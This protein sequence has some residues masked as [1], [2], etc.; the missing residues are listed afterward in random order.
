MSKI[1][2]LTILVCLIAGNALAFSMSVDGNLDEWG[3]APGPWGSSDW[4]PNSGIAN[5]SEDYKPGTNGGY[6]GPGWG[7]QNFDVEALYVTSD[8]NNLYFAVVTGFLP[9]ENPGYKAGDIAF[10]F[11]Q[12]G[13]Y[14]FGL[15]AWSRNGIVKGNLYNVPNITKW[16]NGLWT[17]VDPLSNPTYMKSGVGL[18]YGD[19]SSSN[20]DYDS[21]EYAAY[22]HF[23]LEGYVPISAFG[24]QWEPDVRVHWTMS[25]GNDYLNVDYSHTP[26]PATLAL[27]GL[28]LAGFLR[29]RK[30]LI[31]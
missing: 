31:K 11:G 25:C 22:D 23:V 10:D 20:F 8:A 27:F 4:T 26:E 2:I 9:S 13:S 24:S 12:N 17:A 6:V 15:A 28:G 30:R 1:I 16:N 14:E 19:G 18:A 3:V 21:T 29:R 5:A 7:R